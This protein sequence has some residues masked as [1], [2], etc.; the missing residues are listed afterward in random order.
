[1]DRTLLDG[2]KYML[3]LLALN[4]AREELDVDV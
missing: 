2:F 1:M 4:I 3:P